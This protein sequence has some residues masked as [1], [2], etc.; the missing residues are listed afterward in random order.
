MLVLGFATIAVVTA[1]VS[2]ALLT[3]VARVDESLGEVREDARSAQA[4]LTIALGAREHYRHEA[5]AIIHGADADVGPHA[6]WVP[7]LQQQA[8]TLAGRVP[9][10]EQWHLERLSDNVS[11]LDSVFRNEVLPASAAGDRER[12]ARAHTRAAELTQAVTD[13]ADAVARSLERRMRKSQRR[14]REAADLAVTVGVGGVSLVV[15]LAAAFAVGLRRLILTPLQRLAHAAARIGRGE[16]ASAS[17]VGGRGEIAT[18]AHAFEDMTEQ[19]RRREQQLVESERM[20]VVGQLA[21][22]VAHEINNPIAVIRGYLRTMIPEASGEELREELEILDEEATACQRIVEDLLSF[23][24]APQ[25][26]RSAVE[27]TE[28]LESTAER[29]ET[30]EEG[31]THPVNVRAQRGEL[32]VDVVRMRQVLDNLLRNAA[33]ASSDGAP[34]VLRGSPTADGYRIEVI[35]S[36]KGIP[37]DERDRV[38]EPF[39]S[40]RAEGTGLGLAVCKAIVEAHGGRIRAEPGEPDGTRMVIEL[41]G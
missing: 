26:Q 31:R 22:G 18:V 11:E 38:F 36:G 8:R 19:L 7:R 40:S 3:M 23:A 2:A 10:G 9:Q 29:F 37:E 20:A 33:Q 34:M 30:T 5:H 13:D 16:R 41:P 27:A 21:A 24:R 1:L 14:A 39:R 35:D 12:L 32:E 15:L 25:L 17:D 4:A 6:E 28:L